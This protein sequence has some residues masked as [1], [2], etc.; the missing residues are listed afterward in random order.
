MWEFGALKQQRTRVKV[1]GLTSVDN[2]LAV[3]A[4]GV[5]AIGLVFYRPSPRWVAT[6][7]A[8]KIARALGPL[9]HKVGLFVN[10]SAQDVE[11]VLAQVELSVLQFHGDEPDSFC[12]QFK[13]PFFKAL[14]MQNG[15]DIGALM[16]TYPSAAGFLLDAYKKGVPGGTG[17][18]FDWARVPKDCAQPL[19][20]A[21]GLTPLNVG[22]AIE[23][24]AVYGVDVSGG[25]E[26][27][28]G[29]KGIDLVRALIKQV[30]RADQSK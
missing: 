26:S 22:A 9:T 17:E 24:T 2:A 6:D 14:R 23:Q 4:C 3:E 5:D 21:G 16:A 11:Q 15:V 10:A 25:V 27:A 30:Q 12:Q 13:R 18:S 28:P 7:M 29:V 20:L 19:L 8:A 1:C